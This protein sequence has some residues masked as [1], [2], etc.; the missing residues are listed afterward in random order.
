MAPKV[1]KQFLAF[2]IHVSSLKEIPGAVEA[3]AKPFFGDSV[4]YYSTGTAEVEA[5]TLGGQV[6]TWKVPVTAWGTDDR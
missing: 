3:I 4:W 5:G 1:E 2:D 6:L